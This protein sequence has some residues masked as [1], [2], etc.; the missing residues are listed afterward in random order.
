MA[1][2]GSSRCSVFCTASAKVSFI[3]T[4]IQELA[5]AEVAAKIV[6]NMTYCWLKEPFSHIEIID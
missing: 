3:A 2:L 6:E 1:R 5:D 4:L